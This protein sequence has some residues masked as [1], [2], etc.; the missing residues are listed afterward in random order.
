VN[1]EKFWLR[2]KTVLFNLALALAGSWTAFEAAFGH[3]QAALTPLQYGV[4]MTAIGIF[5]VL[6]RLVTTQAV[7]T[8]Q[9]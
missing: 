3:L 6:L 1:T 4:L 2:S 5:G 7:T 8:K 9:K